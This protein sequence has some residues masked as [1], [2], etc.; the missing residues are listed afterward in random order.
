M[1]IDVGGEGEQ[2]TSTPPR[3]NTDHSGY[4]LTRTA[5]S[6]VHLSNINRAADGNRQIR[7]RGKPAA[8][9]LNAVAAGGGGGGSG[10]G[11]RGSGGTGQTTSAKRPLAVP[12]SRQQLEQETEGCAVVS[13]NN[14]HGDTG[15]EVCESFRSVC[16]IW[17]EN[18]R[19]G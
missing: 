5:A 19:Y 4:T 7:I 1:K 6:V 9:I 18:I 16:I 10:G 11:S 12:V 17:W 3:D 2:A 14:L 15:T 8:T 13:S